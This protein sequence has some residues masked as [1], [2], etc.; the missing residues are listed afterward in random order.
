[1]FLREGRIEIVLRQGERCG[2]HLKTAILLGLA[3]RRQ[4]HFESKC[5]IGLCVMLVFTSTLTLA[6]MV[7]L[8]R[9]C[10]VLVS[11]CTEKSLH[12]S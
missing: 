9:G 2:Q 6:V 11:C 1:M 10:H 4:C 8:C 5:Q 7:V 12:P 3:V